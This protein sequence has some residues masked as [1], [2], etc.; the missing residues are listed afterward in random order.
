MFAADD[1]EKKYTAEEKVILDDEPTRSVSE[2]KTEI[3]KRLRTAEPTKRLS[4]ELPG[5]AIEA[6]ASLDKE[7]VARRPS[8]Q[9]KDATS[10]EKDAFEPTTLTFEQKRLSFER[11]L[12]CDKGAADLAKESGSVDKLV[13]M[14]KQQPQHEV[15]GAVVEDEKIL[16][17]DEANLKIE[18]PELKDSKEEHFRIVKEPKGAVERFLEQE[19]EQSFAE[20]RLSFEVAADAKVADKPADDAA[21]LAKSEGE[22]RD[23]ELFEGVSLGLEKLE[24]KVA[25]TEQSEI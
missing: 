9:S 6:R 12:S 14:E 18:Q 11:G 3:E 2:R 16:Q 24:A 17:L 4:K 20:K 10:D 1:D 22:R 15:K 21:L 19:R 8:S 23:S 5:D 7:P 25:V 13:Q